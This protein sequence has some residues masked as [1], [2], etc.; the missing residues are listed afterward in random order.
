MP[1]VR[2]AGFDPVVAA[3]EER[4]NAINDE[5]R[6][7]LALDPMVIADLGGANADSEPN[8]NVMYELGLRHAFN[9]PVVML[10]WKNQSLPFD[11]SNQRVIMSNRGLADV[12]V[13][14]S[15]IVA[16]ISAA[17]DG[18]YYRP[19]NAVQVAATLA[20]AATT[21]GNEVL[22]ALVKEVEALRDKVQRPTTKVKKKKK[23]KKSQPTAP[24]QRTVGEGFAD[25]SRRK[26]VHAAFLASG[27]SERQW[28]KLL[29][30]HTTSELHTE[31]RK[32]GVGEWVEYTVSE[33]KREADQS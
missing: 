27:G 28:A 1:A 29:N 5:I 3:L 23:K 7:H 33:L 32:W 30:R 6:T 8:P 18:D 10:A 16:F 20:I 9:L 31:M 17:V 12:E 2:L 15:R 19:M 22:K 13:N 4:P 14:R 26:H 21:E 11:I 25:K 24:K